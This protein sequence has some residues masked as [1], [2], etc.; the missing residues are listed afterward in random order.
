MRNGNQQDCKG[1][2]DLRSERHVRAEIPAVVRAAGEARDF[3]GLLAAVLS[4]R[5]RAELVFQPIVDMR[6]AV[7]T[8]YEAL[9]RFPAEAGLAPNVWFEKAGL[10]GRRNELQKLM[11]RKALT[12]RERLPGNCFLA[13]NAGPDYLVSVE[14]QDVLDE[15]PDLAGVVVEITE[16][17]LV[18]D[19]EV[20]RQR[21][22]QIRAKGGMVAVDDA[23]VGYASLQH[24]L[25]IRPDFIKI[26]RH[27]VQ[28]CGLNRARSTMIE[29]V[30]A[31]ADRLDAAVIA[32][33]VELLSE[34]EELERLKVPLAQ[35]YLLGKPAPEML[36]LDPFLRETILGRKP[37]GARPTM[38]EHLCSC[39]DF[40]TREAAETAMAA[41]TN[42]RE[43]L[44]VDVWQR[45][46]ELLHR[47]ALVG[48]RWLN[49]FMR[50]Q[51]ESHPGEVLDR[52]LARDEAL[53]FDPI[54]V[55]GAE[56]QTLGVVAVDRLIAAV[57][58]GRRG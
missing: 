15:F 17:T 54:V 13:V 11:M 30:G 16:E 25:E 58:S 51:V 28:N 32:E 1:G 50:V 57:L 22:G 27:F 12:A 38:A 8:G 34:L 44:V 49:A 39:E 35:G 56:G 10:L 9:A 19:Y 48:V 43:A 37:N 40:W 53:R 4:E 14:W 21:L 24:I 55:I 7:V 33:G 20:L 26:D 41:N 47:H 42:L 5:A 3:A 36:A 18:G 31:A 2:L 45:P 52:A 6:D 23:G 29:M 46:L